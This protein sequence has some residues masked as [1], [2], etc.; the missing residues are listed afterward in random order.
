MKLLKSTILI[1][2]FSITTVSIAQNNVTKIVVN[3]EVYYLTTEIGYNLVGEY[4]NEKGDF[5]NKTNTRSTEPI[6]VLNADGTGLWQNYGTSKGKMIWGIECTQDGSPIKIETDYGAVYSLWYMKK[7]K[8]IFNG[9]PEGSVDEWDAVQLSIKF[10]EEKIYILGE[11][12]KK[13][14]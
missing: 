7:E 2:L 4:L 13:L 12:A 14:N 9:N 5:N 8:L 6:T 10:A 11:R 1:L 3:D